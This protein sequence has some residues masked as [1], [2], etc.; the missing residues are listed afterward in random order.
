MADERTLDT[1][2]PQS[3]AKRFKKKLINLFKFG[4][5]STP[6]SRSNSPPVMSSNDPALPIDS[7]LIS[8]EEAAKLRAKYTY[9]RI[10]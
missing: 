8:M 5:K 1:K 7:A 4:S 9:F 2:E 3:L 6:Q 10:L